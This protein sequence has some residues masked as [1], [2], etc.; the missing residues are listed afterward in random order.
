MPYKRDLDEEVYAKAWEN[1]TDKIT[2]SVHSYN[3]GPRKLQITREIKNREGQL[4]YTKL[5][6]LS[7]EEVESILPFIQEAI[8]AM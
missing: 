1:D 4:S 2:V 3:K 8:A 6:R 7:K 5:G